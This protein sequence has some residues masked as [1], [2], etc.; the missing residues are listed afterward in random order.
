MI[1][2]SAS[3]ENNFFDLGGHSL[4]ATKIVSKAMINVDGEYFVAGLVH[5]I[6]KIIVYLTAPGVYADPPESATDTAS[7]DIQREIAAFGMGHDEIAQRL[8]NQLMETIRL[9]VKVDVGAPGSVPRSEVGK[10]KRVFEQTSD[11]DPMG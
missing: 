1:N 7:G 3:I 6:G 5:D 2:I 4:L 9:R 10:A 11:E 8:Q